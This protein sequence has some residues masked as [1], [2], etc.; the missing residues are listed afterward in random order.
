MALGSGVLVTVMVSSDGESNWLEGA[1]MFAVYIILALAFLPDQRMKKNED[2]NLVI[3][4]IA[5]IVIG[6]ICLVLIVLTVIL[7]TPS[8]RQ[9]PIITP[10]DYRHPG[11]DSGAGCHPHCNH[12]SRGH[13]H[14]GQSTA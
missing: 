11:A 5:G 14:A 7:V 13:G 6:M 9:Y 1:T 3:A 10:A 8:K 2:K 12:T 4:I